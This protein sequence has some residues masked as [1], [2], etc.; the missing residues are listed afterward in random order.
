MRTASLEPYKSETSPNRPWCVDVPAYLSDTGK[1]KRKFFAT[2]KEAETECEKLEARRDNFGVS[3]TAMTPAR[4]A[5]AAECYKL[6]EGS[7]V[8][9]TD[10]VRGFLAVQKVRQ[11]KRQLPRSLGPILG[12]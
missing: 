12:S 2:K 1:R 3:L 4:I 7:S 11:V 10:A 6:L 8:S 9:L 5:E